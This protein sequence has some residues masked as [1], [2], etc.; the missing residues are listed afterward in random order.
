MQLDGF[1]AADDLVKFGHPAVD[2]A[3]VAWPDTLGPK[4][5]IIFVQPCIV[6]GNKDE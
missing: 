5:R 4:Q 3:N 1:D 2:P 6:G